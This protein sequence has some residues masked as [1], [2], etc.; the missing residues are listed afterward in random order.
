MK[1]TFGP[2][3]SQH[4]SSLIEVLVTLVIL[5]LGLLGLV[6]LMVQSQR[7][8]MESYQ[9]MQ[10]LVVLQDMVNRINTN[11]KAAD[12]Y[13]LP[14]PIGTG[15]FVPSVGTRAVTSTCPVVSTEEQGWADRTDQ[16]IREW[17]SLLL[18]SAE[19]S[20]T[21]DVGAMLG[22]RGCITLVSA[23]VYQVSVVWQGGGQ[24]IAPPSG[25]TCGADLYGDEALRRAVSVPL[26]IANL[27]S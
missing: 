7:S 15:Y 20:G 3:F 11:R 16:D 24:T 4:G 6:G 9:R 2:S 26:Q 25:V 17:N 13:A 19:K 23:G 21:R 5:M 14:D 22:A 27:N 12:C 8:Q 18:G 1:S 10:A